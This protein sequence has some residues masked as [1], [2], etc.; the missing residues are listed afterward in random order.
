MLKSESLKNINRKLGDKCDPIL[1]SPRKVSPVTG[2]PTYGFVLYFRPYAGFGK[3]WSG[4]HICMKIFYLVLQNNLLTN[5]KVTTSNQTQAPKLYFLPFW[6]EKYN[7][8]QCWHLKDDE[9]L[10]HKGL[11]PRFPHSYF[12]TLIQVMPGITKRSLLS[13]M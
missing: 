11:I 12:T 10:I 8:A 2:L 1:K 5:Y 3:I 4:N 7:Y 13:D 9:L 6:W